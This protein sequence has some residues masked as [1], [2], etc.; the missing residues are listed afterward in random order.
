MS[1]IK[2]SLTVLVP[3]ATM[4]SEQEC[5]KQ[6]KKPVINKKGKYAGKPAKDKN[7]KPVYH[8]V[9]VPD[10]TKVQTHHVMVSGS[11][12]GKKSKE[13]LVYYTRKNKT[14]QQVIN[15]SEEAYDYYVSSEVP[16]GYS[17]HAH[18][19]ET[20]SKKQRLEWH[21]KSICSSLGGK[22]G[23]YVVFND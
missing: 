10:L 19:W 16:H 20:M 17:A 12:D 1:N 5:S 3:G 9:T 22:M 14:V 2:I 13:S 11:K 8:T 4:V 6:L 7:G 21:L 23:S 18:S 15:L